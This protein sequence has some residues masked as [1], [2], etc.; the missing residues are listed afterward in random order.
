M[1]LGNSIQ[2]VLRSQ[3]TQNLNKGWNFSGEQDSLL[4]KL[5]SSFCNMSNMSPEQTAEFNPYFNMNSGYKKIKKKKTKNLERLRE[6][7]EQKLKASEDQQINDF[8][9]FSPFQ[10]EDLWDQKNANGSFKLLV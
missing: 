4:Q 7:M 10:I 2:Y 6:K 3:N 5:L 1:A 8:N 9:H